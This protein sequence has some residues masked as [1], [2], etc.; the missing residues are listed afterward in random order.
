MIDWGTIVSVIIG[1]A[2]TLAAN[3]FL[4]R[5]ERSKEL[6]ELKRDRTALRYDKIRQYLVD[7]LDLAD[8]AVYA[9]NLSH[10]ADDGLTQLDTEYF[11][12]LV[13][14]YTKRV[15]EFPGRGSGRVLY[16]ADAEILEELKRFDDICKATDEERPAIILGKTS[17]GYGEILK[18][19]QE[20]LQH[21]AIGISARLDHLLEEIK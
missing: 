16:I 21:I 2:V 4:H 1:G 15:S 5:L 11:Q 13:Q 12:E 14:G 6:L 9:Y 19:R 8:L 7:A 18:K 20:E 10:A 17:P 3:Y